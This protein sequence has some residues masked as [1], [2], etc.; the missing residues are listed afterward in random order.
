MEVDAR[1]RGYCLC[2]CW[3]SWPP[4]FDNKGD[5]ELWRAKNK[6]AP[7]KEEGDGDEELQKKGEER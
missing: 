4:T 3:R 7:R 1:Q 6:E 5:G 2:C